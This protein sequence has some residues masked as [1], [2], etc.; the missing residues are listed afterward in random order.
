MIATYYCTCYY[1]HTPNYCCPIDRKEGAG[2]VPI[3]DYLSMPTTKM[4]HAPELQ[5]YRF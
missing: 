5:K 2:T 1:S 4:H 3:A